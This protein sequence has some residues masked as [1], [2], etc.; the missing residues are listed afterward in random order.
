MGIIFQVLAGLCAGVISGMGFGGGM[1]L[2]PIL[3]LVLGFD[4]KAAQGM[5]LLY[6][7]PTGAAAL[8]VH[9]KNKNIN[10][11]IAWII[12]AYGVAGAIGGAMLAYKVS[13]DL[14]QKMFAILIILVGANEFY[15]AYTNSKL[16]P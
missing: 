4:Q 3:T 1:V 10:I 8:W 12:A 11:K 13:A 5:N 2:I 15:R 9:F 16:N 14:L 6:F 7:I